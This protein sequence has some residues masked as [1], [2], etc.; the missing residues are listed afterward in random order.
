MTNSI[1]ATTQS[2]DATITIIA[3]RYNEF[4]VG[5]LI[6]AAG[7]CLLDNAV[8]EDNIQIIRVPGAFEIPVVAEVV[9]AK[10]EADGIIT[11]GAVIRG[12]T[13]HFDYI[14]AECTRGIN[15]VALRHA[16]PIAFGVL[17]VDN[18][19]QAMDRSGSEESNK[20]TESAL[21]VLEMI[22]LMSTLS[23]K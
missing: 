15:E 4:I 8:Q 20:G 16:L 14:S 2:P 5:R 19:D 17:T 11:L 22:N 6:K 12:E 3:S 10:G 18:V 21:T 7:Q 23:G 13:P 9:A 1:Q